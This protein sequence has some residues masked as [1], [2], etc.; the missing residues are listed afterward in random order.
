MARRT[1][2]YLL[3][4]SLTIAGCFFPWSCR[5]IADLGWHC[6][7]AIVLRYSMQD[8]LISR[9]EIQDNVR[10]SGFIILFL[11]V[12]IVFFAFF[13]PQVIGRSKIV[14]LIGSAVLVAISAYHFFTMLI[15]QTPDGG[16]L[17]AF[18]SLTLAIVFIGALM[19]LAAG[20]IDQGAM[21]QTAAWRA[22]PH[23]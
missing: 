22:T 10:G 1:F 3:G 15:A 18:A 20:V 4:A 16:A 2:L 6:T 7:T 17:G 21:R 5:Q 14:A 8:D 11:T 9:L 13:G 23:E 12:M 19:M